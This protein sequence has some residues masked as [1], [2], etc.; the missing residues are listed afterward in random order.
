MIYVQIYSKP[1][2]LF[3]RHERIPH[4]NSN[5]VATNESPALI[6]FALKTT[7]KF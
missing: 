6:F 4:L 5:S 3:R 7:K 1:T 2:V